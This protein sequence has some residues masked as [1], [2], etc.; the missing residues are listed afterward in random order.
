MP[1]NCGP[2]LPPPLPNNVYYKHMGENKV[3]STHFQTSNN[4]LALFH[5]YLIIMETHVSD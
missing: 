3:I 1:Y 2:P 4:D 5:I